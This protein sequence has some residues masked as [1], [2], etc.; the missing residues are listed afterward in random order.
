MPKKKQTSEAAEMTQMN[1]ENLK[2]GEIEQVRGYGSNGEVSQ[3]VQFFFTTAL[4]AET[5]A[6]KVSETPASKAQDEKLQAA[7]R[8]HRTHKN[9]PTALQN[10]FFF[11]IHNNLF[12]QLYPSI[13]KDLLETHVQKGAVKD[14]NK[15]DT[16]RP[17]EESSCT[18]S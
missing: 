4:L 16:T 11:R 3:F 1:N 18:I 6:Q 15:S 13:D 5:A 9:H 7:P 17:D 8:V 2:L 12:G 14:N 10:M